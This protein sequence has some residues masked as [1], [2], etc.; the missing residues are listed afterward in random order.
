MPVSTLDIDRYSYLL[1][2]GPPPK[3]LGKTLGRD[4]NHSL[5]DP[6]TDSH[7]TAMFCFFTYMVTWMVEFFM[8]FHVG[9]YTVCPMD[10]SWFRG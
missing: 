2:L 5:W 1:R 4:H 3:P 8:G 7:G 6:L 9:K 10:P